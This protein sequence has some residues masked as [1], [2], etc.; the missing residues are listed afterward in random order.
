MNNNLKEISNFIKKNNS[1]SDFN[2]VNNFLLNLNFTKINF[3]K[4]LLGG[5]LDEYGNEIIEGNEGQGDSGNEII[6][7]NEGQGDSGNEIIEGNEGQGDFGNI[8]ENGNVI[9]EGNDRNVII[10]VN[11]DQYDFGNGSED[12]VLEQM[13]YGDY[14]DQTDIEPDIEPDMY[15]KKTRYISQDIYI[16]PDMYLQ[17]PSFT[18]DQI[19]TYTIEEGT[20]LYHA[21]S[22]KRGFNTNY[23]NLGQDNIIN[24]FTPNFRLASDK[25]EGCSVDKQNGYIHVFKVIKDIPNIYIRLPYDI[26]DDIN[27][28]LLANEFC[29]KNQNYYGIGFFYPKNN[30]EMFS[31]NQEQF[32]TQFNINNKDLYYSEFGLCNPKPYLQYLYTQRCQSLR[33]LSDPYRFN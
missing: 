5:A 21:T 32:N 3:K 30:I 31:N 13:S 10:K 9:I 26:A 8:D 17:N 12:E 25:I 33:R 18:S 20:L 6:E 29:S 19:D 11:D 16:K 28:G 7:G 24:F 22:N 4:N 2:L 1:Y 14:T 23:L 15:S 27:S